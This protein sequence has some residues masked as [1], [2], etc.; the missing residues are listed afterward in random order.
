MYVKTR[1]SHPLYP[2]YTVMSKKEYQK[3]VAFVFAIL[4][5]WAIIAF[6]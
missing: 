5:I 4:A 1:N 2:T 3:R 6:K